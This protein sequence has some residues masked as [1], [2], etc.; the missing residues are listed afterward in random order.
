[1]EVEYLVN[2]WFLT[3]NS[4]IGLFYAKDMYTYIYF[5]VLSAE[6]T[7]NQSYHSGGEYTLCPDLKC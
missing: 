2:S 6:K 1:M 5:L 3:Y 4:E 7:Y